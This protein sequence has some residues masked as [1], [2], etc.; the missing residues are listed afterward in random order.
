MESSWNYPSVSTCD[1]Q[2]CLPRG[3]ADPEMFQQLLAEA[4]IGAHGFGKI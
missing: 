4:I 3:I 1:V 2:I